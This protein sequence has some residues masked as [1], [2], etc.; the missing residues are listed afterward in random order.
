MAVGYDGTIR[1]DTRID[2]RGF[3]EGVQGLTLSFRRLAT[4]MGTALGVASFITLAKSAVQAAS[5]MEAALTGLHSVAQGTGK[6][7]SGAQKF[8]QEY[9][10]D[11]LVPLMNATTAY[12][13]LLMRGY[14]TD[15]IQKVLVALKDSAAFGRQASLTLGYAVQSATEGLKNE[16]SILVDN[17]GVTKNVSMMWRDYAKSIGA[18]TAELT[19]QQKIQAEVTG[20][21]Y[22][23]RFQTG[24]A[25][26]YT[27]TY[28]GQ[29]QTLGMSFFNLRVAL[30]NVLIP[31]LQQII[32]LLRTAMDAITAFLNRAAS[33]IRLLL[34]TKSTVASTE[35]AT[36][37][38]TGSAYEAA[39]AEDELA[40]KTKKAADAAKNSL[41][42]FD[43]L[44]VLQK[45]VAETGTGAETGAGAG[46]TIPVGLE[47]EDELGDSLN[48]V[49]EEVSLF[50]DKLLAFLAPIIAAFKELQAALMPLGKTI[51]EGLQWAWENILLPLATW[52]ASE[53]LPTFLRLLAAGATVLNTVLI[54]LKPLWMWVWENLFKPAAEW[55]GQAILDALKWLTDRLNDLS[56]WIATHPEEFQA[57]A[58]IVLIIAAAFGA[59]TLAMSLYSIAMGIG[60]AVTAAFAVV[61]AVVTSPITLVVL[62]IAALIA[63]IGLL[64]Y[65]WPLVTKAATDAWTAIV[66][67][68]NG[69]GKWFSDTV[70]TPIKNA[71]GTALDWIQTKWQT[72][73]TGVKDFARN[74][75]NGVIGFLNGMVQAIASG[76]N[77][78][79]S[80]MNG[81]R[82]D[83]P[84][85]VPG[86]GGSSWGMNLPLVSTPQIP[87]LATGAVIP[88][89]AA[90]AAI[91]GDQ[92]SGTNIEAPESLIREI[93]QE[94]L[95]NI[96]ADVTIN[97]AGTLAALVRELKPYIDKENVRVG[98]SMVKSGST[99]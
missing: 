55:T 98:N 5:D 13:N 58:A 78:I 68:W 73:F 54:A 99:V 4:A 49:L 26:R 81:L 8:I 22:E 30:G 36:G 46:T 2:T 93:I 66:A 42:A 7:F 94:E 61:M 92:T 17:A 11:G 48:D 91:L 76:L 59:V 21:L 88:P 84:S 39:D 82:I 80:A 60:T 25:A 35:K 15:Q 64:I 51:W 62:A 37:D 96:K 20:I 45:S 79:I 69:A 38:L 23:T 29:V 12:K 34:G 50:K 57:F 72:I 53:L 86:Y 44:D 52:T 18:T 65:N 83:I 85:W 6:S 1:I 63:I 40:K 77:A 97:F 16:F 70:T 32:P 19:K 41:A 74:T 33:L 89:N 90:F 14:S 71:F 87:R 67:A 24:D 3:N 27:E 95:G 75:F 31:L 28:A 43:D 9:I 47:G 10:Q 56:D